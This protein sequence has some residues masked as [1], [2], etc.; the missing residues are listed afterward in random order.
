VIAGPVAAEAE[1]VVVSPCINA[2]KMDAGHCTGCFRSLDEIVRWAT[3]GDHDKRLIL[4]AVA[5]RRSR[6]APGAGSPVAG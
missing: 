1:G 3:A 5:Q 2:C 6:A 4:A